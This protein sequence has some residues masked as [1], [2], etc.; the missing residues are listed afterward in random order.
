MNGPARG[1]FITLE[2][3]EGV[4]KSTQLAALAVAL[5]ERGHDV[6]TTRAPG[7]SAGAEAIRALLLGGDVDAWS[8]AAEA[9][10]FAAARSDHVSRV[11]RPALDEGTWVLCDRFIDSTR[12][13]Q[14][15]VLA[16]PDILA[17]HRIGSGGLMPDRTLLL[18]VD[19]AIARI[20]R[21]ARNGSAGDRFEHRNDDFHSQ[22]N[23]RFLA[24][25]AAEPD[26]FRIVDASSD[27][28][29]VTLALLAAL[30]DLA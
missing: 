17:L 4:G 15:G 1:R 12:A 19:P 6:I 21:T 18:T 3:G 29:S 14:G 16:D 10:L 7:G 30:A 9:L 27:A 20:R 2:G 22:V 25:A 26:R 24:L 23:A 11:I 8:P 28:T 5:R 13:Y